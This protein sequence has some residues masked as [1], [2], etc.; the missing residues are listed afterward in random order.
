M[1]LAGPAGDVFLGPRRLPPTFDEPGPRRR[2]LVEM[3][4]S[5]K[6]RKNP[7]MMC[8]VRRSR[9]QRAALG[10]GGLAALGLARRFDGWWSLGLAATG[11]L[12]LASAARSMRVRSARTPASLHHVEDDAGDDVD[13]AGD[14]SFPASDPPSWSPTTAG[15][16]S[17]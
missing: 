13:R 14:A 7:P 9:L 12:L 1:S 15:A 8:V 2:L 4:E 11:G 6:A 10:V 3:N 17:A 16:P 5:K